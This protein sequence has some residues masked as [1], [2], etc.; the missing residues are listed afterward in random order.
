MGALTSSCHM[1]RHCT[2]VNSVS[3]CGRTNENVW[4]SVRFTSLFLFPMRSYIDFSFTFILCLTSYKDGNN[5]GSAKLRN[6]VE[7]KR[8][9]SKKKE[10][11]KI[12]DIH[13]N[14]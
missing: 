4:A 12:L 3:V 9:R 7:N 13:N 11:K 5:L 1:V 8:E 10:K 14:K 2:A 6:D